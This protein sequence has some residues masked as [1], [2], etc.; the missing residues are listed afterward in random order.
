MASERS[1]NP[2][3]GSFGTSIGRKT[4]KLCLLE[5]FPFKLVVIGSTKRTLP[6]NLAHMLIIKQ[7]PGTGRNRANGANRRTVK[8]PPAP[9]RLALGHMVIRPRAM[10]KSG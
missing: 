4:K 6:L 9:N 7:K 2:Y 10:A 8:V 5:V 1:K 3:L